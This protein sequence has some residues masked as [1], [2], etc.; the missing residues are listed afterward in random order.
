MKEIV[1]DG[2]NHSS[3]ADYGNQKGDGEATISVDEQVGRTVEEIIKYLDE[4]NKL[5]VGGVK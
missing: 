1:I 5:G 4:L 2:G 3:F